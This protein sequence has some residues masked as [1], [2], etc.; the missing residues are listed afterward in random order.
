MFEKIERP[1]ESQIGWRCKDQVCEE[2][3]QWPLRLGCPVSSGDIIWGSSGQNKLEDK[4]KPCVDKMLT[5]RWQILIQLSWNYYV[6]VLE[7]FCYYI[8]TK[9]KQ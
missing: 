7:L 9:W 6:A 1:N 2:A 5:K 3:L 8:A 4:L